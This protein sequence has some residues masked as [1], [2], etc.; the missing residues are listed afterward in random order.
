ME[1]LTDRKSMSVKDLSKIMF[2]S[3]ATTRRDLSKMER[4]GLVIK[5][6]GGVVLAHMQPNKETSIYSRSNVNL[7]EKKYLCSKLTVFLHDNMCVF[8][9]SSTTVL[10]A[11]SIFAKYKGLIVITNGILLA[12]ELIQNTDNQVI[13]TGGLVQRNTNSMLGSDAN[14]MIERTHVDLAILSTTAYDFDF[15]FSESAIEQSSIKRLMIERADKT[16]YLIAADKIGKKS[17]SSTCLAKDIDAIIT[18][19]KPDDSLS[20]KLAQQG[21][22]VIY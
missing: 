20:R 17:L 10:Q 3:D 9:D 5:T 15:G 22:K 8:A 14:R 13:L 7:S 2:T 16:V 12:S 21:V 6:F 1:V 19:E 18:N 4:Q 11:V